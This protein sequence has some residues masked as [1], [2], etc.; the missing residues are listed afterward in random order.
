MPITRRRQ[1]KFRGGYSGPAIQIPEESNSNS[2]TY[3]NYPSPTAENIAN[4]AD[5]AAYERN[6]RQSPLIH[7]LNKAEEALN[8]FARQPSINRMMDAIE[9]IDEFIA[10]IRPLGYTQVNTDLRNILVSLIQRAIDDANT[11][12]S[13]ARFDEKIRELDAVFRMEG[14]SRKR[15]HTKRSSRK[16]SS[17]K[18][19]SR[20]RSSRKRSSRRR[21][22][23]TIHRKLSSLHTRR[24]ARH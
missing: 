2:N 20:K 14:G 17:R 16:R 1:K 11:S 23:M 18:R 13:M 6:M 5:Q 9:I 21:R 3:Y 24:V 7:I 10:A 19:S 12:N 4:S 15:K 8:E 22:G